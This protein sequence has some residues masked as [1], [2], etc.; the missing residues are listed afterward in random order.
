MPSSSS[1]RIA[2]RAWS[3]SS[4]A[5][6]AVPVDALGYLQSVPFGQQRVVF[7]LAEDVLQLVR[8]PAQ[9]AALDVHDEDRV[10]VALGGQEADRRHVARDQRVQRRCGPVGDVMG[11]G[12]HVRHTDAQLLGQQ[13]EYVQ[14]PA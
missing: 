11:V 6:T 12:E 3:S 8:G 4:G 10:T 9:V 7:G 13:L 5:T 14:D 2:A 1:D